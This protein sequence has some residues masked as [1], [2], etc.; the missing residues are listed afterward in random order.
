M[1]CSETWIEPETGIQWTRGPD[2]LT[3]A[4][5]PVGLIPS[6]ITTR[7][8]DHRWTAL[9]HWNGGECPVPPETVVR[10]LFRG[11]R[12]YIG[13]A[14]WQGLSGADACAMWRH[15]PSPGRIDPMMDI[16]AYQVEAE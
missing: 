13:H 3:R 6:Y 4:G 15:A 12:P 16:V 1:F 10:C 14:I 8:P 7:T 9:R 5:D 11:R 2:E